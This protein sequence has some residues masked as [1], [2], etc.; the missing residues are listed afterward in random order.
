MLMKEILRIYLDVKGKG[1][2]GKLLKNH[3]EL[4]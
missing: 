2:F 3:F 4:V 1:H